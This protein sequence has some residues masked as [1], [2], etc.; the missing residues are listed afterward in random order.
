[1]YYDL[2]ILIRRLNKAMDNFPTNEEGKHITTIEDVID[3]L[4]YIIDDD[5]F[6]DDE[7]AFLDEDE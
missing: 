4:Q 1:M 7:D 6:L 2:E 3:Y 5:N